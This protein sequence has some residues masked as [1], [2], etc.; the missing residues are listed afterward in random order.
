VGVEQCHLGKL[1]AKSGSAAI[2]PG[3]N[4]LIG[5]KSQQF[6]NAA[7]HLPLQGVVVLQIALGWPGHFSAGGQ[8]GS[9]FART[10]VLQGAAATSRHGALQLGCLELSIPENLEG[11]P[12]VASGAGM[13]GAADGQ[14]PFPAL[15]LSC[16]STAEKGQSLER[17]QGGADERFKIRLAST[18]ED[19]SPLVAHH[20]VHSVHRFEA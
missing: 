8:K 14:A 13:G 10:V 17:L 15:H 6:R 16:R 1:K 19:A 11:F 5:W 2:I 7:I 18:H 20:R 4:Q 9:M 3:R 12:G